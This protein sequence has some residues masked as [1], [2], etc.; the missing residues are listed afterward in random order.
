MKYMLLMNNMSQGTT[1]AGVS[2]WQ[3]A[4]MV[5]HTA[6]LKKLTESLRTSGELVST[7]GLALPQEAKLVR[8]GKGGAPVIDGVFPE[9]KEFLAGYW[10]VEVPGADRAY[11]IAAQA[12]LA[13][14]PG[15]TPVRMAIEV[16]RVM[17]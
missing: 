12:S 17:S 9:A 6:Y 14:G 15:G 3:H 10:I 4:D 2:G 11:E 16:R 1:Y 7:E 13:P 8:A 5:S